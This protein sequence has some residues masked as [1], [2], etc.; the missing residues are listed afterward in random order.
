DL[1]RVRLD[2]GRGLADVDGQRCGVA[3][4]LAVGERVGEM[5]ARIFG[6]SRLREIAIIALGIDAE[7]AKL[8]GYLQLA[9][10]KARVLPACASNGGD[11]ATGRRIG[12]GRARLRA[13]AGDEI[14]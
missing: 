10:G 2:H 3:V 4:P 12:A 13:L 14:A 11:M 6:R 9:A 7:A 8:A 1:L 5:V